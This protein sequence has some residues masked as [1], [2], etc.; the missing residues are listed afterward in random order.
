M[1][2]VAD[3]FVDD[4]IGTTEGLAE[5]VDVRRDCIVA[6]RYIKSGTAQLQGV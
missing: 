6:G 3:D 1:Y 4:A 5:F 2:L